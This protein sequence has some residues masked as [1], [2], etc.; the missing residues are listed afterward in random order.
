MTAAFIAGQ[1]DT[2]FNCS[3]GGYYAA[4]GANVIYDDGGPGEVHGRIGIDTA[5]EVSCNQYFAQMGV[6]LGPENLKRA[7]HTAR[8]RRL[9]HSCRGLA[10]KETAA[11]LER[12]DRCGE[13]CPGASEK[14]RSSQANRFPDT[15]SR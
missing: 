3:G 6:K 11:D 13:A 2:E 7:A 1:Q 8:H 4:P 14:P 15:T 9:R 5:Y 10:R 12:F